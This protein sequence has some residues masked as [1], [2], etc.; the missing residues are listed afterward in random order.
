MKRFPL[1]AERRRTTPGAPAPTRYAKGFTLIELMIALTLI[2]LMVS[3]LFGGIR[4]ANRSWERVDGIAERTSE[5]RQVWGFLENSFQRARAEYEVA[6]EGDGRERH[7]VF[8]GRPDAVEYVVPLP[9]VGFGGLNVVRLEEALNGDD[10]TL[11][12]TRWLYHPD[13]SGGRPGIPGWRSLRQGGVTPRVE[14]PESSRAFV[15]QSVL[16]DRLVDLRID[17]FGALQPGEEAQWFDRWDGETIP[18]L[19][20]IAVV[21]RDG[22]WPEMIFEL[23]ER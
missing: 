4:L 9:D 7:L 18:A 19:V 10:K 11:L 6:E 8:F 5:M 23:P 17:Y 20:R 15:S 21:D 13:L 1:P 22:A 3:L 2:A 12:L 14:I 16:V